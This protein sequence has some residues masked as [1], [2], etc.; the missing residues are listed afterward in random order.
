[1]DEC[2]FSTIY[3]HFTLFS[4]TLNSPVNL[5]LVS[6][7]LHFLFDQVSPFCQIGI[8]MDH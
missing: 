4:S 2:K 8:A 3:F 1:M 5:Q 6:I 7:I